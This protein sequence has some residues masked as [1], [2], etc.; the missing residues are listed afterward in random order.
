MSLYALIKCLPT[1]FCFWLLNSKPYL[2]VTPRHSLH[3][4]NEA[5]LNNSELFLSSVRS[6]VSRRVRAPAVVAFLVDSS[7]V[8]LHRPQPG[9][10]LHHDH[11]VLRRAAQWQMS[12]PAAGNLVRT[13]ADTRCREVSEKEGCDF[14]SQSWCLLTFDHESLSLMLSKCFSCL[15]R[16]CWEQWC[17]PVL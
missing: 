13:L 9:L 10:P 2:L 6:C 4:C 3:V 17:I 12:D 11:R 7:G 1:F 15:L 5:N 16:T 8:E 14:D